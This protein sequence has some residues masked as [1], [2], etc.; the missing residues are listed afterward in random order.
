MLPLQPFSALFFLQVFLLPWKTAHTFAEIEFCLFVSLFR[1]RLFGR[2][3]AAFLIC[4]VPVGGTLR[5]MPQSIGH[6]LVKFPGK[7]TT[8]EAHK[9]YA[10]LEGLGRNRAY[11]S[12]HHVI[13]D[14]CNFVSNPQYCLMDT[15]RI[16]AQLLQALFADDRCLAIML[17]G[18][19]PS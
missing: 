9:Y 5:T 17:L 1:F 2:C 7:T 8:T 13:P 15:S 16:I 19:S 6:P 18:N 10:S 12:L 4:Q 14:A 3:L 11:A